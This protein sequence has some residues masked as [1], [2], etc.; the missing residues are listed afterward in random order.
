[1]AE[2]AL[3]LLEIEYEVLPPVLDAYAAMK[4]DAPA[5][6][7]RLL[8]LTNP[9]QRAGGWGDT[10]NPTNVSNHFEFRLGDPDEGFQRGRRGGGARVSTPSRYTR[11]T[12]SLTLPLPNGTPAKA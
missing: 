4:D 6:H 7:E 1:M 8:T 12:S 11:D 9:A 2:Q 10:N 5:L 3:D